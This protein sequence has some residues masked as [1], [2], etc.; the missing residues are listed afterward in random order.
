V[1]RRWLNDKTYA[2]LVA[3]LPGPASSQVGLS[4]GLSCAGYLGSLAAWIGFTLPSA[5]ALVLFAYGVEAFGGAL[6]SGWAEGRCCGRCRNP[7]MT[8]RDRTAWLTMQSAAN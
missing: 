2:D 3:F 7:H 5:I 8:H 6:D 4:I 1:R